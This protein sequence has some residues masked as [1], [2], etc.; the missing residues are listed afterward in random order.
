[1]STAASTRNTEQAAINAARATKASVEAPPSSTSS[2]IG[3]A[4][5]GFLELPVVVVLGVMWLAG[6]A[7]MGSFALVVYLA[8]AALI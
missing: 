2:R 5:E 7:F 1:V 6:A 4:Y 3:R 8:G